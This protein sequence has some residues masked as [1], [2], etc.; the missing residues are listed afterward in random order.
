MCIADVCACVRVYVCAGNAQRWQKLLAEGHDWRKGKGG[1]MRRAFRVRVQ[2]R[3]CSYKQKK[4]HERKVEEGV[5]EESAMSCDGNG[6]NGVGGVR[7]VC[8]GW[9]KPCVHFALGTLIVHDSFI[10][11]GL[12]N[13]LLKVPNTHTHLANAYTFM[14]LENPGYVLYCAWH[15]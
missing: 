12:R 14:V 2:V 1:R 7:T 3:R 4:I 6:S 5:N 15:Y 11:V 10:N 8:V 13:P 9:P